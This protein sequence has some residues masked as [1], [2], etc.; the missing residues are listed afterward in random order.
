M[1]VTA[2]RA[3]I[4]ALVFLLLAGAV[5]VTAVVDHRHKTARMGPANVASWFCQH[6]GVRCDEPQ[7]EDVA[8]GWHRRERFYRAGFAVLLAVGLGGALTSGVLL[9]RDRERRTQLASG[10]D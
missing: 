8:G 5:A 7:A 6:D 10:S 9:L 3:A 1:V 4:V 2:R